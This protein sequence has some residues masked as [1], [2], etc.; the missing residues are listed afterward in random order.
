MVK[1][2]R[3]TINA[4]ATISTIGQENI[5][6]VSPTSYII[7]TIGKYG[8]QQLQ[9]LIFLYQRTIRKK[10]KANLIERGKTC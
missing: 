7:F 8:N 4:N 5:L 2:P 3:E 6:T 9:P 10:C 1:I